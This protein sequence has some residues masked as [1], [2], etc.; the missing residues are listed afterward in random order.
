MQN[1]HFWYKLNLH[2]LK[3]GFVFLLTLCALAGE[4]QKLR[5][6]EKNN[7]NY[8]NRKLTYGFLIGL[9]TTTYQ[10]K[11]ADQFVTPQF[12][13]V[14][15]VRPSWAA[16]FSLGFIVNYRLDDQLDIRLTPKVGFY[17]HHL[18]YMYTNG[19][20]TDNQLVET[21]MVEFPI[22]LKYKSE[23]RGN[24]RMYMIGGVVPGI[25]ASG[26][27]K[28]EDRT[29]QVNTTNL[30]IDAGFGFDLYYPLFKF[31]PELRFS[32]G[33]VNMLSNTTDKYGQPLKRVSTNT[34]TL[35]FLFQ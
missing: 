21:T 2:R 12:D 16:G 17:E 25:E 29:L 6:V 33:L 28:Q 13:T 32:H 24:V 19:K 7:P 20:P 11:Y 26:K 30:S 5:W 4:A 18:A 8:D 31:S 34:I 22:L 27:K 1:T 10:L 15:A 23:R 9:H 3:I 35:Y 14:F